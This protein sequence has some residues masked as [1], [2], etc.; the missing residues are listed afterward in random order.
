[1]E[2]V[3]CVSVIFK[4]QISMTVVEKYWQ[5]THVSACGASE[6]FVVSKLL[7]AQIIITQLCLPSRTQRH[8]MPIF[9]ALSHMLERVR[10]NHYF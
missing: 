7:Y 2:F 5:I 1:M 3:G 4:R 9:R 10:L 8:G 6:S